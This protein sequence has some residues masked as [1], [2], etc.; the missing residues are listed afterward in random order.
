[1][2]ID[3]RGKKLK[4]RLVRSTFERVFTKMEEASLL[5]QYYKGKHL[6]NGTCFRLER[7]VEE[8]GMVVLEVSETDFYSLLVTN[9][10][11]RELLVLQARSVTEY[12]VLDDKCFSNN[13][14]ISVVLEDTENR[15][16]LA[17][18]STE[19]AIGGKIYATSVTGSFDYTDTVDDGFRVLFDL[20]R[21]EVFEETGIGITEN[22]LEV[23]GLFIGKE[24]LQPVLLCKVRLGAS[25]DVSSLGGMD[26]DLEVNRFDIV[27]KDRL[28][29]YLE[30][31]MTE[32]A[33]YHLGLEKV[34]IG[35]KA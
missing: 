19:V 33:R 30:M 3:L 29:S 34:N 9:L 2:Y 17:K 28:R 22:E 26:A 8:S 16:L 32:V 21:K 6:F 20:V 15:V 11:Y 23:Q 4:F 35:V 18:R 25:F 1:M 5:E 31:P 24:K 13:L 7:V 14:A 27:S 10:L 12:T